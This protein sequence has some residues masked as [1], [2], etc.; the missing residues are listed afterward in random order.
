[1]LQT[2]VL[3]KPIPA[4]SENCSVNV[5][6]PPVHTLDPE[7]GCLLAQLSP[8]VSW[9]DRRMA[10]L[11]LGAKKDPSALPGLQESMKND[12]FWMVRCAIVQALEMIGAPEAISTLQEIVRSDN[13]QVVRSY[14][15]KAVERLS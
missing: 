3:Q 10:A 14:A 1:M 2:N 7:L 13:Y 5:A 11:K 4:A 12:S 8:Q 6:Q 9:G 15:A